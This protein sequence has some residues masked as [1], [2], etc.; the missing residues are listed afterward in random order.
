M[1]NLR[2]SLVLI[3]LLLFLA[4]CTASSAQPEGQQRQLFKGIDYQRVVRSAPRPLVIHI[5]T[6]KLKTVGID[7]LVTPGD[8]E[9]DHPVAAQTTSEFLENHNLQLAI[10][11]GGFDPWYSLGLLG[12]YPHSG[13]RVTPSGLTASRGTIY[14][15]PHPEQ[16]TLYLTKT[17]RATID[18]PPGNIYNAL[19]GNE[20]LV[21][22]GDVLAGLDDNRTAP[23]TAVG[24]SQSGNK[25][26]LVLV[27][28]RQSGYSEGVTLA[29]LAVI[30]AEYGIF[31]AINLDGG[32]STTLVIAGADGQPVVLNSPI[33]QGLA[34]NER[35]VGSHLGIYALGVTAQLDDGVTHR[36]QVDHGRHAGEI[37][38]DHPRR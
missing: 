21:Q 17:N 3:S 19:S 33:H 26:Y 30:M 27:D 16:P 28:G 4:A 37:L 22:G 23:R 32:G 25:L 12:Y 9:Q 8:L 1:K 20:F 7:T 34:D 11:G 6:I 29:E 36:R 35:P 24:V 31:H 38:Q 10:N 2:K 18:A 15:E 13:D 14:T 5:V